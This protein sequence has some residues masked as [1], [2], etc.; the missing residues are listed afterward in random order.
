[1]VIFTVVSLIDIAAQWAFVIYTYPWVAAF[2]RPFYV[3][4]TFRNVRVFA[5]NYLKVMR[6]TLPMIAFI[7]CYIL[8]YGWVGQ[9][10]Y[11]GTKQG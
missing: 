6:D 7:A 4:I 1:M 9:I 3:V 2:I 8:Y 11:A 5:F 10:F